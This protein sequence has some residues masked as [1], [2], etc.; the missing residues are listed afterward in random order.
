MTFGSSWCL[1]CR[2]ETPLLEELHQKNSDLV[3][4]SVDSNEAADVV[5]DYVDESCITYPVLLDCNGSINRLYE[6]IVI[7]IGLFIDSDGVIRAKIVDKVTP[8]ILEEKLP[9]IGVDL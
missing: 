4:P 5:Q 1:D 6:V 7:P 2:A 3:M 8:E 9:L